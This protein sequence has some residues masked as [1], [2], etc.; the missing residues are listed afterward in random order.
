MPAIKIDVQSHE[1][2]VFSGNSARTGK[3]FCFYKQEA[4]AFTGDGK[5]PE[6]IEITHDRPEDA[7]PVGEYF[8]DLNQAVSVDRFGSL[9]IDTRKMV[10]VPASRVQRSSATASA[11]T[12]AQDK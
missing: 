5:Y 1:T 7:L 12:T 9:G 2:E 10:F 11:A 8:V 6:K 4:F 3:P